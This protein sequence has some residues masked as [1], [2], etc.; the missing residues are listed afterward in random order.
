MG[1][2]STIDR[3]V[4]PPA[5]SVPRDY[6]AAVDF[7]DRNISEGRGDKVAVID[8]YGPSYL[9]RRCPPGKQGRQRDVGAW[10][11]DGTTHRH[12]H[13]G[14]RRFS[15]RSSS[16]RIKAG[17]V[18]VAINTLLTTADYDYMLRDSR[19]VALIVSDALVEKFR[20]ILESLPFLKTVVVAGPCENEEDAGFE[21]L[22]SLL[23]AASGHLG[24]SANH[25]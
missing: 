22:D 14:Y 23:A 20:P 18:P 13:A 16:V 3:S 11:P 9:C 2:F 24:S 6:N 4:V 7:V 8:E 1:A 12:V 15:P 10:P 17:V 19:A 21:R 25:Q 5:V